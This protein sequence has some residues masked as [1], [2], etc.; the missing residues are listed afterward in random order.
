M[1]S[2]WN[3]KRKLF[4]A[5]M[6]LAMATP[7]GLS[8]QR[9]SEERD[10]D[11]LEQ[12]A[13]DNSKT[14]RSAILNVPYYVDTLYNP[15]GVLLYNQLNEHKI[16]RNY[17][18][19]DNR[20]ALQMYYLTHEEWH[21]HNNDT[22]YRSKYEL[23]P[24]EYYK[25]CMDDEI[26]ANITS[27]C[28]VRYEYL[29][30]A[31]KKGVVNKYK[32]DK[33]LGFYFQKIASGEIKPES[34]SPEDRDKEWQVIANGTFDMWVQNY[35]K[36]YTPTTLLML[37]NFLDRR[38]LY[39]SNSTRYN[40]IRSK[41]Y[42]IGGVDFSK[43]LD[44][45]IE[46][47]DNMMDFIE[48]MGTVQSFKGENHY[49]IDDIAKGMEKVSCLPASYQA[50]ALNHILI[51]AKMKSE[52][53]KKKNFSDYN[54]EIL[55]NKTKH[56]LE[57]DWSY[58]QFMASYF[59]SASLFEKETPDMENNYKQIV[60][61]LYSFNDNAMKNDISMVFKDEKMTFDL[62]IALSDET[63]LAEVAEN[64]LNGDKKTPWPKLYEEGPRRLS[65]VQYMEI[66]NYREPILTS[67]NE[68][69]KDSINLIMSDFE[70]IPQVLK[71][72]DTA[73]AQQYL[74][75]QSKSH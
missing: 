60:A 51:S 1:K 66:P 13:K 18:E 52:L 17:F 10:H 24:Q 61:E 23:S 5:S 40:K 25:L 53:R 26:T 49:F 6:V 38:G 44:K 16:Y 69:Q 64:W 34:N 59:Q 54:L 75:K 42:S 8:C 14:V 56:R 9:Q 4:V 39:P 62:G 68:Q 65:G 2:L 22:G 7:L 15:G 58:K 19:K 71:N 50:K 73:A 21:T 45:E 43:Y 57:N 55:Y 47:S 67:A 70:K 32:E 72:C 31:D 12:T 30:S 27:V 48:K 3:K 41:M 46:I 63:F 33:R 11:P 74:S 29:H 35:R 37:K 20:Y 28:T 36:T